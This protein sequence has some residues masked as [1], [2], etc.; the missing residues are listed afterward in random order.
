MTTHGTSS[1]KK[2]N[3]DTNE[4]V[5]AIVD[6]IIHKTGRSQ[7]LLLSSLSSSL[8]SLKIPSS[9]LILMIEYQLSFD[10]I[11]YSLE[12]QLLS[13]YPLPLPIEQ[14]RDDTLVSAA[15]GQLHPPG[16]T[17][18]DANGICHQ[19]GSI[20]LQ[21]W[22]LASQYDAP[23]TRGRSYYRWVI[24]SWY[25][26]YGTPLADK[27]DYSFI[28]R[29]QHAKDLNYSYAYLFPAIIAAN[30]SGIPIEHQ[31]DLV[32]RATMLRLD[33]RQ[34]TP[35]DQSNVY[36][37]TIEE[38]IHH[39]LYDDPTDFLAM[40]LVTHL[41]LL[42]PQPNTTSVKYWMRLCEHRSRMNRGV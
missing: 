14:L 9:L 17:L 20:T 36:N 13:Y 29:L 1:D 30:S 38:L 32:G 24:W 39:I 35:S 6:R 27:T 3:T 16:N 21:Y 42:L 31:Q 33:T 22:T 41:Y 15:L 34:R 4:D 2:N 7:T 28:V 37:H 5:S 8:E 25:G 19:L 11:A 10:S 40:L 23:R 26:L 12:Q 18:H